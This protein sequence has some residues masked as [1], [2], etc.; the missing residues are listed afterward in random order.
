M[1]HKPV[2]AID[3]HICWRCLPRLTLF[4]RALNKMER[5]V[6][7]SNLHFIFETGSSPIFLCW[8]FFFSAGNAMFDPSLLTRFGQFQV[9]FEFQVNF[10]TGV[11]SCFPPLSLSLSLSLA[12]SLSLYGRLCPGRSGLFLLLKKLAPAVG[13]DIQLTHL[14]TGASKPGKLMVA[15]NYA[16]TKATKDN[17]RI[18]QTIWYSFNPWYVP[19][20]SGLSI[21]SPQTMH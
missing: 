21:N 5:D 2:S 20:V 12:L 9:N 1:Q 13:L 4:W 6:S 15:T 19:K 8:V 10:A 17:P 3:L 11:L 14:C 18:T 16:K 7:A